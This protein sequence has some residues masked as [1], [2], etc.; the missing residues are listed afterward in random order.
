MNLQLGVSREIITPEIGGNLY[1]Y[2]PDVYSESVADDL[3]L[4][5]FY[6]EQGDTKALMMSAT[7]CLIQT[8]MT[9]R[10]FAEISARFGIP[11]EHCM[12]CATHT[13][14]GPIT[15]GQP[16]WGDLDRDYCEGIF[17]PKLFSAVEKAIAQ[18]QPVTVGRAVGQSLVGCN[19]RELNAENEV[20]LGQNPWGP[21]NPNMT[22]LSFRAQD[23]TTVAN[24]IH[25]G[26]HGTAAGMNHEITRDW[27]GVMIDAVERETGG[28][29]AFF[30]GPEGDVGPRLSNGKTTGDLSYVY[31]LGEVAAN[32]ALSILH[33][34]EKFE[35]ISL[36]AGSGTLQIP[37]E[38]RM[39][40]ERAEE[41]Y[42][43]HRHDTV[44]LDALLGTFAKAVLD[45][46]D[47]GDEEQKFEPIIQTV[48]ALGNTVFVSF[49]YE[50]FSEIGMRLDRGLPQYHVCSLSNSNG[51]EGYF[52]TEDA[53]CRGGYEVAM[54]KHGRRIEPY[55]DA[56]DWHLLLESD[57]NIKRIMKTEG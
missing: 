1:G 31:E 35:E 7:V 51:S 52:V 25:Y 32:D 10:I 9:E 50:L 13:H 8:A 16:G 36:C 42:E 3:T 28:I 40:R 4:T 38:A 17:I 21:F 14:S 43:Q 49:P 41:L 20:V 48:I 12:L 33:T 15:E 45:A 27:S 44:N 29:T 23:G 34:I 56:A 53:L 19:R 6:F 37:L 22:V 46:Y 24:M 5:A 11:R 18:A 47:R 26:A 39:P 2:G 57:A 30:N 55:C 54:F